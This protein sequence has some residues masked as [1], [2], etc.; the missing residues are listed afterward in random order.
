M[1]KDEL[2]QLH[3]LLCQVK[4]YMEDAGIPMNG[5]F[6]E[7]EDML[8]S[9]QHIHKSKTDH[10]RAVFMLGKGLTELVLLDNREHLSRLRDRFLR[11]AA[12]EETVAQTSRPVVEEPA[13]RTEHLPAFALAALST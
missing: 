2:L 11:L 13:A 7:Y 9:P 4:R 10:K 12:G 6:Q 1:H 8:V 3:S 5:E